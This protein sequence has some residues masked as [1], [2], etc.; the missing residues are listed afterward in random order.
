[1]FQ[2]CF[3]LHVKLLDCA[4]KA[5]YPFNKINTNRRQFC[6]YTPGYRKRQS[7][8][9]YAVRKMLD[10]IFRNIPQV[11]DL[12]MKLISTLCHKS[13]G[14]RGFVASLPVRLL[15]NYV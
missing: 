13:P 2:K 14:V 12:A 5:E 15:F 8:Y 6:T 1:M 10:N 9:T 4:H 7:T 3:V 11:H